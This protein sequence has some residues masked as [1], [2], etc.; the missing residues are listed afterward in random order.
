MV[1][2]KAEPNS[3]PNDV[4]GVWVNKDDKDYGGVHGLTGSNKNPNRY[5]ISVS[6]LNESKYIIGDPRSRA[7]NNLSTNFEGSKTMGYSGDN[8]NRSLSYYHPTV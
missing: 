1:A 5:I 7:V 6:A 8:N 3:K 4:G 2:I